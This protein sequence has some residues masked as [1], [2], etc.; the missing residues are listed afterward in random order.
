MDQVYSLILEKIQRSEL[1]PGDRLNI[2]DLSKEFGVSRTPLREAIGRLEEMGMIES[3][4]NVGPSVAVLNYRK[5]HEII[6]ANAI[7]IVSLTEILFRSD[8]IEELADE[9]DEIVENQRTALKNGQD[10]VFGEAAIAFHEAIIN[11]CPNAILREATMAS[12]IRLDAFVLSYLEWDNKKEMSLRDHELI[13]KCIRQGRR[14]EYKRLLQNHCM[15]PINYW[16]DDA[17]K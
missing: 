8:H 4:H 13:A 12:Q 9:L 10:E 15:T 14:D 3:K 17:L 1:K 7:M 2:E 11:A 5:V 6:E 16:N